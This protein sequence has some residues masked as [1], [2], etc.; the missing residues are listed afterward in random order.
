MIS[1]AFPSLVSSLNPAGESHD[2]IKPNCRHGTHNK[3]PIT[4]PS[5]TE[6]LEDLRRRYP[7]VE[8]KL[9]EL[10]EAYNDAPK[11]LVD[12][13]AAGKVQDLYKQMRTFSTTWKALGGMEKKPWE[14]LGDIARTF[15]KKAE[16]KLAIASKDLLERHTAFAERKKAAA[17][18]ALRD[19][20]EK[21]RA[22]AE[23][24]QRDAEAAEQRRRD[25]E[26]AEAEAK[27]RE[28]RA[29]AEADAAEQR[30][31]D[32]EA[33]AERAKAEE[34]RIADEKRERERAE[35]ESNAEALRQLKAIV[36][37]GEKTNDLIADMDEGTQRTEADAAL[38]GAF[39]SSSDANRLGRQLSSSILLTDEQ[40][41]QLAELRARTLAVLTAVRARAAAADH[42]RHERERLEQEKAEA[43]AAERRRKAE[44]QRRI[45]DEAAEIAR[46]ERARAEAEA[47]AAKADATAA[48]AEAREARSDARDAA[49]DQKAAGRQERALSEQ[50]VKTENRAAR[51]ENKAE[52]ASDAD[53]SR[54]R[55]DY[56]TVGGLSGIWEYTVTDRNELTRHFGPLGPYLMDAAQ[57]AAVYRFKQSH[58]NEWTDE[59]VSGLIPGVVFSWTPRSRIV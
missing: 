21:E 34:K 17:E 26:R 33:A 49:V 35:K 16:D 54:T 32:A 11:D 48:K 27:E 1:R 22:A 25:A 52:N 51:I 5:E 10:L 9:A 31:R 2:R 38:A 43:E 18:Q 7:D 29:K 6:F 19:K 59:R 50:A 15:F 36:R 37:E 8:P 57:D 47:A 41:A 14:S 45:D 53:L 46:Q 3:P 13:E 23:Q 39:G 55:G 4:P 24:L 28:L 12:D 30:K 44:E 40:K 42:A 56:G 58:Q 20:A